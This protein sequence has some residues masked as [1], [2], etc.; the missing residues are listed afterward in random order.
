VGDPHARAPGAD[1]LDCLVT[2]VV[3]IWGRRGSGV[4]AGF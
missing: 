2:G 4:K 3:G 1:F